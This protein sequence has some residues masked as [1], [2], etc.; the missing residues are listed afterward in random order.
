M[1]LRLIAYNILYDVKHKQKYSNIVINETFKNI[2]I[3]DEEKNFVTYLC[4]G[5]LSN[6]N[7]LDY[8]I[9][10]YSDI[11]FSKIS[12]Q[13]KL[14]L[15]I[16]FFEL[17][18]MNSSVDYATVNEAV[19]LS[20]KCD[21]RGK[22]FVNALLRKFSSDEK[23]IEYARNYDFSDIT[24]DIQ[25]I[26]AKYSI[27][28]YIAKRLLD[29]YGLE[30]ANNLMDYM[31][32]TPNIFIRANNLKTDFSTL[33]KELENLKL[34]FEIIDEKNRIFS[35]KNFKNIADTDIYKKGL[36]SI[37]DYS[38][39]Q[40][41]LA[42]NPK[43]NEK[44][45]DICSA[46][47]GKSIF[48]SQLMNNKG[49]LLSMDI[50]QNKLK[51][52]E[53]QTK[54]LGI[55]IITTKVNDATI[56][57]KNY[58]EQFDKILADVPCSG[59]GIIRRKPEIRYKN[60][61]DIEQIISIQKTILS[62]CANYLKKGGTL[63]YSTCTLGKEENTNIVTKFLKKNKDFKLISTKEYYPHIDYTDGFFV[64]VMEKIEN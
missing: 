45:L 36:F 46:P 44:I 20:K 24:D 5:V 48:I 8:F 22:N 50:S 2:K 32:D 14:V 11:P 31:S 60:F 4:Y 25:K 61:D 47:G 62:N 42:L 55:D 54:R 51:L 12:K 57:D 53:Q 23:N 9:K 3:K 33:K 6:I 21:F 40:C 58:V 1:N 28:K 43:E 18:F 64:C 41:V 63:V 52:L 27:S 34:N 37:Q 35:I 7:F 26:S 15:E 30:F 38:S 49:T 13:T 29:N 59:I 19:A 10:K 56:F 39:M 17:I 16:A